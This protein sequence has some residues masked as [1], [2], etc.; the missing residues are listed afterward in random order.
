MKSWSI[1]KSALCVSL[2]AL[3][4]SLLVWGACVAVN[5]KMHA[6]MKIKR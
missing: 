4:L 3:L 1:L 5:D 6:R 2:L